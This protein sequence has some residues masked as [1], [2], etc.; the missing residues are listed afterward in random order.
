MLSDAAQAQPKPATLLFIPLS[1]QVRRAI[2]D[3]EHA[4]PPA[5]TT[6]PPTLCLARMQVY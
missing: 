5:E 3:L 4:T 1:K 2:L 6:N